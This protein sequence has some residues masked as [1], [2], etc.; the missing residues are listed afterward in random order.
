MKGFTLEFA[1]ERVI[2]LERNEDVRV[3]R[4]MIENYVKSLRKGLDKNKDSF[5]KINGIS[6]E[7]LQKQH[8]AKRLEGGISAKKLRQFE[9]KGYEQMIGRML[10]IPVNSPA[11]LENG[12]QMTTAIDLIK[13]QLN[14]SSVPNLKQIGHEPQQHRRMYANMIE[15]QAAHFNQLKQII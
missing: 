11:A 5:L 7:Q 2:D 8:A 3:N 9:V 12:D 10:D 15:A 6:E 13:Q 4:M 14:K 1:L